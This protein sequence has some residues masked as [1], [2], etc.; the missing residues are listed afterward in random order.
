MACAVVGETAAESQSREMCLYWWELRVDM[1]ASGWG[2]LWGLPRRGP[3]E[4]DPLRGV[5]LSA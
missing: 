1:T 5:E 2:R 3:P 4:M